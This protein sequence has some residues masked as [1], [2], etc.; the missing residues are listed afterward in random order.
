[1]VTLKIRKIS[2]LDRLGTAH[3]S[4]F[5]TLIRV[6]TDISGTTRLDQLTLRCVKL[7]RQVCLTFIAEPWQDKVVPRGFV[8]TNTQPFSHFV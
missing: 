6:S 3:F 1:V 2:G 5:V 8:L 4:P 7:R